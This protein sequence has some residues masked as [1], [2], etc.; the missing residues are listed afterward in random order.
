VV[1][2]RAGLYA[3]A[4]SIPRLAS[5]KLLVDLRGYE[6]ATMDPAVHKVQREVIPNFLSSY[7]FRTGFIEF[8]GVKGEV[9]RNHEDIHCLAV[10]HIHHEG[11][12]LD[13][14]RK[15]LS[16]EEESFFSSLPEAEAWISAMPV[17][18]RPLEKHST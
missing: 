12:K 14:Y 17:Q 2:W 5:F 13:L 3:A 10:A 16:R 4:A 7:H 15:T 18:L 8:F 9:V 1:S 6:V 11:P